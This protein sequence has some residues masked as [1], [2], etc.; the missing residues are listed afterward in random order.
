MSETCQKLTCTHP[1]VVLKSELK[2]NWMKKLDRV[3]RP[4]A[5]SFLH[6][7]T[8]RFLIQDQYIRI[9][10]LFC[11]WCNRLKPN[12]LRLLIIV[13]NLMVILKCKLVCSNYQT[14][15]DGIFNKDPADV[16]QKHVHLNQHHCQGASIQ[17]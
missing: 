16:F 4:L 12:W 7:C 5:L 8:N 9:D 14:T 3:N 13:K 6:P 10:S 15:I 1:I 2:N 17:T 11:V